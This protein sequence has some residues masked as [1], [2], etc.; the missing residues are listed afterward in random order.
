MRILKA[1]IL[2]IIVLLSAAIPVVADSIEITV[3]AVPKVTGGVENF[4]ITYVSETE[5]DL[6]WSLTGEANRVMIRSKWGSYPVDRDDGLLVYYGSNTTYNDTSMD[7]NETAG[8]LY[9]R[10]WAQKTD[11]SWYTDYEEGNEENRLMIIGALGIFVIGATYVGIR[12]SFFGLK[13]IV[14]M[15]WF[16]MFMYFQQNPISTIPEGGPVHVGLMVTSIGM[17]LMVVLSGLGRGISRSQK[18]NGGEETETGG[19]RLKLPE[20]LTGS[21][22]NPEQRRRNTDV[23]L[24]QYRDELRRAYRRKGY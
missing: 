19:F 11:D 18:W 16:V 8:T 21:E 22:D 6:S 15:L 4:V 2:V 24:S 23:S 3:T 10:V 13:L 1:L 20:W 12:S 17:G 7:F 5:L 14:G 9:Y